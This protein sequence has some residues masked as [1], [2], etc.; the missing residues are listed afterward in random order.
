[1]SDGAQTSGKEPL[2]RRRRRSRTTRLP[3]PSVKRPPVGLP[4]VDDDLDALDS[5][6][7]L[8]ELLVVLM[9]KLARDNVVDHEDPTSNVPARSMIVSPYPSIQDFNVF[10]LTHGINR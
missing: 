6:E 3:P 8:L 1:M 4:P 10:I 7:T 2:A 9:S 5:G